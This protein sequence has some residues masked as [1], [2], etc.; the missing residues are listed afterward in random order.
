MHTAEANATL[1]DERALEY[2]PRGIFNRVSNIYGCSFHPCPGTHAGTTCASCNASPIIPGPNIGWKYT[3]TMCNVT[4]CE[5]KGCIASHPDHELQLLRSV[6]PAAP[7]SV[8]L[9]AAE[10]QKWRVNCIMGHWPISKVR[11][12]D[13]PRKFL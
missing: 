7:G 13:T 10:Q 12:Y 5:K 11:G 3:C 4:P 8:V 2:N 9:V 6:P 1:C